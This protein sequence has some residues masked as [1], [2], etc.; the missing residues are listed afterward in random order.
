MKH[1]LI[2]VLM[3]STLCSRSQIF[4]GSPSIY[5]DG[6]PVELGMK[7]TATDT[8]VVSGARIYKGPSNS[9]F[10]VKLYKGSTLVASNISYSNVVAGWVSIFFDK[11]VRVDP[12]SVY[13]IAY[14]SYGGTYAASTNFFTSSKIYGS[15]TVPIGA[16]TYFYGSGFP[17]SS[18]QNS[19]YYV[20]PVYTKYVNT[21]GMKVIHD[22]LYLDK[23]PNYFFFLSDSGGVARGELDNQTAYRSI[24]GSAPPHIRMKDSVPIFDRYIK[25]NRRIT[26]YNTGAWI[27]EKPVGSGWSIVDTLVSW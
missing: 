9:S 10:Q 12:G 13:T 14:Y 27:I 1:L 4:S 19:N 24:F 7:F 23:S 18:Y 17:S 8:L 20:E 6:K 3:L 22:T 11:S 16:G 21:T 15:I 5:S 2:L 25:N 26:L